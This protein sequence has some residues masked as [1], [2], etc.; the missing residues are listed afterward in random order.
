M[1]RLSSGTTQ[2]PNERPLH[3]ALAEQSP[4]CYVIHL[5]AAAGWLSQ[6]FRALQIHSKYS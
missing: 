6:A 1:N 5:W 4:V 2:A 3:S